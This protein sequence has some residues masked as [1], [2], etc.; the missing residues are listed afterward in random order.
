MTQM[1]EYEAPEL[2]RKI[3]LSTTQYYRELKHHILKI[4]LDWI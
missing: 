3:L 1:P 2:V 4:I